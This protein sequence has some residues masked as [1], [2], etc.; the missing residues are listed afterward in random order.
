MLEG[1]IPG[2]NSKP[3][4]GPVMRLFLLKYYHPI[5]NT[6]AWDI[7]SN[8][9]QTITPTLCYEYSAVGMKPYSFKYHL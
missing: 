9:L 2:D 6:C 3:R 5:S 4:E 1:D 7:Q 8:N